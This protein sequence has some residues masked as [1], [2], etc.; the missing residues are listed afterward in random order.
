MRYCWIH[1][2][3]ANSIADSI[4]NS[5]CIFDDVDIFLCLLLLWYSPL[6]TVNRFLH[7]CYR[8]PQLSI[9]A[10]KYIS[11]IVIFEPM[12]SSLSSYYSHLCL[13][14]SIQSFV[15]T[16]WQTYYNHNCGRNLWWR[17]QIPKAWTSYSGQPTSLSWNEIF[18]ETKLAFELT[19]KLKLHI[20]LLDVAWLP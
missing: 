2:Q 15:L 20:T 19:E 7:H 18:R 10:S 11:V 16:I 14:L 5:S 17:M 3:Y 6:I 13:F 12:S 1:V 4:E 9:E 8:Y